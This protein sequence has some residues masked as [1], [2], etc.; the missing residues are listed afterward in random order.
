MQTTLVGGWVNTGCPHPTATSSQWLRN[1]P[2]TFI[3]KT[4]L[5]VSNAKATG[6]SQ[7]EVPSRSL[8]TLG[9]GTGAWCYITDYLQREALEHTGRRVQSQP[10]PWKGECLALHSTEAIHLF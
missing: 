2:T 4:D 5:S 9:S 7:L 10:F 8:A 3:L 6:Q 1:L